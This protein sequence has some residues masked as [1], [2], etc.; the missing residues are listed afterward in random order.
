MKPLTKGLGFHRKPV[1]LKDQV[2]KSALAREAL[3]KP[4]PPTPAKELLDPQ[5]K[6]ERPGSYD[7]LLRSAKAAP[8]SPAEKQKRALEKLS[9][10]SDLDFT[11]AFPRVGDKATGS[12][13]GVSAVSG[14]FGDPTAMNNFPQVPLGLPL[15]FDAGVRR[16]AADSPAPD[17]L[18]PA[19]FCWPSVVI[20]GLVVLSLALVFLICLVLV[21]RVDVSSVIAAAKVDLA[22]R[23]SL[24]FLYLAVYQ[25]YVVVARSFFGQTLGEWTFD[26]QLGRAAD[27]ESAWYPL[28]VLARSLIV[29]LTGILVLPLLSTALSRDLVGRWVGVQ[30]YQQKI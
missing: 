4:V 14:A 6:V 16:G 26:H 5:P 8:L 12:S 29:M 30:L 28:Q 9:M 23:W 25:M 19:A 1:I 27:Q 10:T 20:D 22:T 18:T 15:D 21:T 13:A 7:D 11:D 2:E 3:P 17:K 24:L